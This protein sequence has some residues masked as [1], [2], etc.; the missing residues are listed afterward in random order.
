MV[1]ISRQIVLLAFAVVLMGNP[2]SVGALSFQWEENP[3]PA[4]PGS[5][6]VH[7]YV[8]IGDGSIDLT[9]TD[10]NSTLV[11][12]AS[13]ASNA[14]PDPTGI[15]GEHSFTDAPEPEAFAL[16]SLGLLGLAVA[17]GRSRRRGA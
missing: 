13:P 4:P 5:T 3:W 16:L 15:A 9:I 6:L 1:K 10:T 11:T 8:G 12:T 7:S 2:R 14:N 17:G